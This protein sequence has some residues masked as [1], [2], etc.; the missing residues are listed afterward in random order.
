M[1]YTA[2]LTAVRE[3]TGTIKLTRNSCRVKTARCPPVQATAKPCDIN[4]A[5]SAQYIILIRFAHCRVWLIIHVRPTAC[6]SWT[7]ATVPRNNHSRMHPTAA[8]A[9]RGYVCGINNIDIYTRKVPWSPPS[10]GLTHPLSS[11]MR[12]GRAGAKPGDGRAG[13]KDK[14]TG[15][16]D[17]NTAKQL[18]G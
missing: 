18:H 8:L 16:S 13:H 9:D 17:E 2:S 12:E 11:A 6:D 14:P 15:D 10:R 5:A 3:G 7:H 1:C 4:D